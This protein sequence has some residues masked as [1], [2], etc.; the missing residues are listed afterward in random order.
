MTREEYD[1]Q[2]ADI[3]NQIL[4]YATGRPINVVNPDVLHSDAL[5]KRAGIFEGDRRSPWS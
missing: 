1:L 5:L 2:F 4:A 3:F